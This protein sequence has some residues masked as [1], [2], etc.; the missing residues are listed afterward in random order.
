MVLKDSGGIVKLCALVNVENYSIVATGSNQTEAKQAYIELLRENGIIG[1]EEI[2]VPEQNV[3]VGDI[4]VAKIR[5]VT[6]DGTSVIYI[7]DEQGTLYKQSIAADESVMLIGE[8]D[9][10]SVSFADTDISQIK[11]LVSWKYINE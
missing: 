3:V 7:S 8:G 11:Q 1:E 9:K 4:T 2:P 10:I 5:T 6:I